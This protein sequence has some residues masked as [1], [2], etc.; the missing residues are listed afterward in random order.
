M[1]TIKTTFRLFQLNNALFLRDF[2]FYLLALFSILS[3]VTIWG[4]L[5][6]EAL[7]ELGIET[8]EDLI[9]LET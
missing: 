8:Y 7:N 1:K 2:R 6:F 5:S 9:T 3:C 4:S